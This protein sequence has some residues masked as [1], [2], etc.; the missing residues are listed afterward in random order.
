M[1]DQGQLE[2][3]SPCIDA[4]IWTPWLANDRLGRA[5]PQDGNAD[6]IDAY[7]IGA[8]EIEPLDSDGDGLPDAYEAAHGLDP[9]R[10]DADEDLDGDGM[11]NYAEY[12]A[13]TRP[14]DAASVLQLDNRADPSDEDTLVLQWPSVSNRLYRVESVERLAEEFTTQAT[15]LPATPPVNVFTSPVPANCRH[16][17]YRVVV[18]VHA[19]DPE[20]LVSP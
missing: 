10:K 13:G 18:E 5:R 20:M 15:G 7:D 14:N 1:N 9:F 6:G 2:L 16:R 8:H 19:A 3:D 11:S 4:G 12:R 17:V